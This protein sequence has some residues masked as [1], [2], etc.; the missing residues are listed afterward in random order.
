[1]EQESNSDERIIIE[2]DPEFL[3]VL[4]KLEDRVK[5]ATWDGMDKISKKVLTKILARKV[6]SSKLI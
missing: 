1:M 6:L 4:N 3:D 2:I 5:K